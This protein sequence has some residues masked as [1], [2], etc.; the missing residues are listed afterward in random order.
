[1]R[2]HRTITVL[3]LPALSIALSLALAG[4][5]PVT[6]AAAPPAPD[7]LPGDTAGGATAGEGDGTS[8]ELVVLAPSSVQGALTEWAK[9]N[10]SEVPLQVVTEFNPQAQPDVVIGIDN[11]FPDTTKAAAAPVWSA[12]PLE[13]AGGTGMP[14]EVEKVAAAINDKFTPDLPR[15]Q[16]TY[17]VKPQEVLFA[18]TGA[19]TAIIPDFL[20]CSLVNIPSCDPTCSVAEIRWLRVQDAADQQRVLE[21]LNSQDLARPVIVATTDDA[22]APPDVKEM[23]LPHDVVENLPASLED[24]GGN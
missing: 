9:T 6:P 7:Q 5:R 21:W 10:L 4:C 2:K 13:Q 20:C 18:H 3:L 1:M 15:P 12:M 24:L 11:Y 23:E 14:A 16:L 8:P 19:P 22:A 17:A